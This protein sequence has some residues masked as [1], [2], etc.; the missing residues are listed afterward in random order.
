ML[1]LNFPGISKW[2]SYS[3]LNE[4]KTFQDIIIFTGEAQNSKEACELVVHPIVFML[5][6]FQSMTFHSFIL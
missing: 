2:T 4:P 1:R 3:V 5:L 6:N